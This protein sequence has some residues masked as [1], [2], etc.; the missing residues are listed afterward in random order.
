MADTTVRS[1]AAREALAEDF[2]GWI[3]TARPLVDA[4]F[5]R[6]STAAHNT[7]VLEA[8]RALMMVDRLATIEAAVDRL[9]RALET[10]TRS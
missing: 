5:P 6:E 1:E 10:E 9:T 7:M 2:L 8:A 3:N 4:H